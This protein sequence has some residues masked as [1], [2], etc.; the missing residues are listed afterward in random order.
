MADRGGSDPHLLN[1]AMQQRHTCAQTHSGKNRKAPSL[2]DC[3]LS[4]LT[5][6]FVLIPLFFL[7][8]LKVTNSPVTSVK[9]SAAVQ[10]LIVQRP[11]K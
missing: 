11:K 6:L 2:Q 3:F 5:A 1:L 8:A 10:S 9:Y 4:A 7:K